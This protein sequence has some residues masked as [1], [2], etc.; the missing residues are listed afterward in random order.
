MTIDDLL[1]EARAR[2]ITL[3]ADGERLRVSAPTGALTPALQAELS[4]HKA[5][6][7]ERLRAVDAPE[8]AVPPVVP[9]PRDGT[10][11]LS[12][13][14]E[15]L[16][17]MQQMDPESA[18]YNIFTVL[19]LK[20][21]DAAAL[22]RSLT[23]LVRR[24]EP[25][26]TVFPLVDGQP[27]QHILPPAPV[28]ITVADLRSVEDAAARGADA[29]R[30]R[31]A[32]IRRPFAL[33]TGP[34][35]RFLLIHLTADE[36]ELVITQHHIAT[37]GWSLSV[38]I[39]DL[40]AIYA[41]F[42]AGR[43]SPLAE[44]PLQYA[45]FAVWQ[46]QTLRG[47]ALDRELAYWRRQLAN[48]QPL[49]L[50]T[51]FPRPA[52][53]TFNGASQTVWI[54]DETARALRAVSRE[55]G[56]SE[57]MA[58][59]ASL[60]IL[61][62]RYTGQTDIAVGTSNGNRNRVELERVLGF[63]VQT[64]VL[65]SDLS[66]DPT[67]R[68][69]LTRVRQA[70]VDALANQDVPFEMLV[71]ELRPARDL[72]RSP[73]L[74]VMFI[75]QN[76]PL[77]AL[78]RGTAGKR[79]GD[80]AATDLTR[81]VFASQT[82]ETDA[83]TRVVMSSGTAQFDITVSLVDTGAGF[84]G[85]IEYNTDL[86]AHATVARMASHFEALVAAIAASPDRR[87]SE[88]PILRPAELR[89]FEQWNET[90][91]EYPRDRTAADLFDAQVE[92]TPDAIAVE[93]GPRRLTYREL[94][95]RANAL[96]VH[97][98][99]QGLGS[100]ARAG[101]FVERSSD[102]V[103]AALAVLKSGGAYVPLDPLY[104]AD[105]IAYMLE[106]ARAS[107]VVTESAL[108]DRL[109]PGQARIVSIDTDAEQWS[110]ETARP[111]R[112]ASASN[113]AYVIYT[114]GSTGRPKGVQIPHGALVNFLTSMVDQLQLPPAAR[115]LAVTTLCFDIAALE[116]YL[117]L[118]TGG[119]VIVATREET[120]DAAKLL[121]R[122]R[123]A[124][125]SVMQ[126]TPA[127]WRMLL[128]AGWSGDR[129][130]RILCGGEALPRTLASELVPRCGG[131]WNMYGPTE[132]TIWSAVDRVEAGNAPVLVGHPIANTDFC[133]LDRDLRPV[134]IGVAGELCIGGD[135]LARGY[136]NRPDL[137]AAAF[138]P[139]PFAKTPGARV[140][141]TGD[142]V[143]FRPDG[144]IEWLSRIDHQV[145][146]RG[147][148][149][150]LGEIE[151]VLAG[152]A[153]V[154]QAVARVREDVAGDARLVAYVVPV[155]GRTVDIPALKELAGASLP[156]YMHPAAYVVL[157]ALPMTPNGKVDR[158]ALPAPER[159]SGARE[160]V[161]PRSEI[162]AR[163]AAVWR[164]VLRLDS[165]SVRENFFDLGGHSLLLVQ[166]QARLSRELGKEVPV[167]EL[168]QFP[169]I[170]TLA[171]HLGGDA[172]ARAFAAQAASRIRRRSDR[173]SDF[174]AVVGLAGR[175]PSAADV[176]AFWTNLQH[177]VEGIRQFSDDELRAAGTDER[178]LAA[179]DFVKA[180]GFLEG[181]ELFDAAFFGFT[182]KEAALMDPQQRLFL[183]CAYEA[184]ERAGYNPRAA[185]AVGVFAGS[186]MNTYLPYAFAQ[187]AL[188]DLGGAVDVLLNSDKDHLAT[189]VSYELNLKGPGVSVQTACSTSLVAVHLACRSLLDG[190]CDMA[191]AGGVS[192][193]VPTVGGYQYVEGNILSPDG[194]CRPF[195]EAAR[196]T[197]GGSGVGIVV[198]KRLDEAIADGDRIRAVIR[199][200]AINNDGSAKVG[201]TA[202]S[203]A[204]QAEAIAAAHAAAGVDP[205]TI[206][207]VEAHGTGTTLG[208]PI[209]MQ[210]LSQVFAEKSAR[211]QYCAIGAVKSNIGH[212]D[213]AAGVTGLIKTVL[214]VEHAELPPTL[215][216][217]TPNPR[218]DFAGS[219][220]FVNR[221]RRPWVTQNG[222]PRRAG[223]SSFGLGGTN[224]HAV[225]EQAPPPQPSA[226]GRPWQPLL[227]SARTD[228]ALEAQAA[229]L[230]AYLRGNPEVNLADVAFTLQDGRENFDRRRVVIGSSAAAAATALEGGD[231]AR[232][233]K[234]KTSRRPSV[235]F[236]FP[237]QG[238]Q[239]VGMARECY[240][241]EPAFRATVD[242]CAALLRA[243]LQLDIRDVLWPADAAA[244]RA[245]VETLC[246]SQITQAAL[247][248]VEY[249]L[250]RLLMSWGIEPSAMVGH[251][252]G[253]Y[254]A[255]AV[256]GA[257]KIE[258]A[259][260]LVALRG[261][262]MDQAVPGCM[263]AVPLAADRVQ[264]M[265]SGELW[266]SA[267]NAPD[268][269]V[270]AGTPAS[271]EAFEARL[272]SEGLD[273]RRLQTSG[274]FH[275]ALMAHVAGPLDA[276]AMAIRPGPAKI[277][278]VSNVTGGWITSGDLDDPGYWG[279]HVTNPVKFADGVAT[280]LEKGADLFVEVGPG[281]VLSTFVRQIA[282]TRGAAEVATL[283]TVR[284]AK[285]EG[286][287]VERLTATIGRLWL[288][289]AE[290]QW[291]AWRGEGR[292]QR[293]E[294]PTYPFE[295]K[296]HWIERSAQAAGAR[297]AA[298]GSRHGINKS[299][300]MAAW[301]STPSWK[302]TVSPLHHPTPAALSTWLVFADETD[303]S[304]AVIASLRAR[305]ATP[306]VATAGTA[307]EAGTDDR[308][309][310][311][312]AS[313]K[314]VEKLWQTL[315]AGGRIPQ[316]I[317]HLWGASA[318]AD[319]DDI[320]ACARDR[321]FYSVLHLAQ[322][323]GAGAA[324]P[325]RLAVV[326]S[327]AERVTGAERLRPLHAAVRGLARV[328]PQEFEHVVTAT[329]DV[330]ADAPAEDA[331]AEHLIAEVEQGLA[332]A[333]VA[334]R[335]GT[336]WT[337]SYDPMPIA[338]PARER[339]PIRQGGVY[340][341]TGGLGRVGLD[342][343]EHFAAVGKAH[344]FLTRRSAFPQRE[345][346]DAWVESHDAQDATSRV[347]AA[348]RR[349][350]VHGGAATV[351]SADASDE[352]QM[353][354]VIETIERTH[355]A[356]NGVIHA[357]G[358]LSGG[359]LGP[360]SAFDRA[361]CERQ[362][363]AKMDGL[364]LL[365]RLLDGRR[366]DFRL[367]MS[368]LSAV[369]GGIG[370]GI[371]ASGNAFLDAFAASRARG[372]ADRWLAVN[373]DGWRHGDDTGAALSAAERFSMT[374]AEGVEALDRVLSLR[375][376][377]QVVV[378]T[379]DLRARLA[380]WLS[381]GTPAAADRTA[382][383]AVDDRPEL[384][385]A[386]VAARNDIEETI[387][388][389]W[390]DLFGIAR[391]GV[392]DNFFALGGHS[393]LA[394]RLA[395]RVRQA[396][397]VSLGL[398]ALFAAPTVAGLAEAVMEKMLDEVDGDALDPLMKDL[399]GV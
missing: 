25:L 132:T 85:V 28:P 144:R 327:G 7:L 198:L 33:A 130:L 344:V 101:I 245:A 241:T 149:I 17:F 246:R 250:A 123:A 55:Q 177:G 323:L 136:F 128:E 369:M 72:S 10:L 297:A 155:A 146:L 87:I 322:A 31:Y 185:G 347:I 328:I 294:L 220:F 208:D 116:L 59:L 371:Y 102:L 315:T 15:R 222:Q 78:A 386:Y 217:Q 340:L 199:G 110:G 306:I 358:I 120:G 243:D 267:I 389:I 154:E 382:V 244:E 162:E 174:I 357:A 374:S 176:D 3:W 205:D 191:L 93:C 274:A 193:T 231:R 375:G 103:V 397:Q 362:F 2:A 269:C 140:Y 9:V 289:G 73:F 91:R 252:I 342:F 295:R 214:A 118:V 230:A 21:E 232:S 147:F 99:R 373:W 247:F 251:S 54:G 90:T 100:D 6:I 175:F 281:L 53:Q 26:R 62:S 224:A 30:I 186:S 57:F 235:V 380:E 200:T 238:T 35:I 137:T 277:P 56:V 398:D 249:A 92:R 94:Q 360:L 143:R 153:D 266:L 260:R 351:L 187:G 204:G 48:V 46:R 212:L 207:Y 312:P 316:G 52:I 253:E 219:P 20:R 8:T 209:E 82:V 381:R 282:A 368:S 348:L 189:R 377:T 152:H 158:K 290:P 196:G 47:G 233:W 334:Y 225:L 71:E 265:L 293:V 324:S 338:A 179:P 117:P 261:R 81:T 376:V 133:V 292:R 5:A 263:V 236:M 206:G 259:L 223:V 330:E 43:P 339:L 156:Q 390:S 172:P 391:I 67:V 352:A 392:H 202:P 126:A 363:A 139:H 39:E 111:A 229:R 326:T 89:R 296:R 345:S 319:R 114:S 49:D 364:Q 332:D 16:W 321:A 68:E 385:E 237:G 367:L 271:V 119:T 299:A 215:N 77:E 121:A 216:F 63:F 50:P 4:T 311:D 135:G 180:R 313:A 336:R 264:T 309:T 343:A 301:F 195:D 318:A 192:V 165:V 287:D 169:T 178:W 27:V 107:I 104:P 372:S 268:M 275:S 161:S 122:M 227:L 279:R 188:A 134:P 182:P 286:S 346:W 284:H 125:P 131:L 361:A 354:G 221:E 308:F 383:Q 378:S 210:A 84:R 168:F 173:G 258:D 69:V 150:E 115:L 333:A 83:G 51:D 248:V 341:I 395:S 190:E 65:R 256:A 387:A 203:V 64:Q 335:G 255:A 298:G 108:A 181:V 124:K 353:R 127:T 141:R 11:P 164:E 75:M 95:R 23:E 183:E 317:V 314:D 366:L 305:G 163:I 226:P 14:Q 148:R 393:L 337:Q 22:E 228:D 79:E 304:A 291:R 32:E 70:T 66:G 194:H 98:Q 283:P 254:V 96:A 356:L 170:E 288:H 129:D 349:I 399:R 257:L 74:D 201:Y 310:I 24:H 211:K 280:L 145:K 272:E 384:D 97:L 359:A 13:G 213:A 307:F 61:L 331:I 166:V 60:K 197:V 239:Y 240:D 42:A 234:Q 112:R 18:A 396:F 41:A 278:Y 242:D 37:D 300:D 109:P 160:T 80:A 388:G 159:T 151:S 355:G 184:L 302:S 58:L 218:I 157:D 76:T 44:P 379:G 303:L 276:A 36:S 370:Y 113:L 19:P 106:D 105:R 270:V 88:I 350:E 365:D 34:V 38:M 171:R 262:L 12:F 285:D 40:T 138:I 273:S 29:Q 167:V 86:F 45:D 142:L 329:I 320:G 325:V 1:A 394:T